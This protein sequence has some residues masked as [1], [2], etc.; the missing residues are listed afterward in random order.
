MLFLRRIVVA[1]PETVAA[2]FVISRTSDVGS[3]TMDVGVAIVVVRVLLVR[4]RLR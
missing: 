3:L 4:L 2:V 1:D